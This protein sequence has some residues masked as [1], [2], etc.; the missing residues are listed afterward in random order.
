MKF[1]KLYSSNQRFPEPSSYPTESHLHWWNISS[2]LPHP[3]AELPNYTTIQ[4]PNHHC[5]TFTTKP[6]NS[7][8]TGI[9]ISLAVAATNRFTAAPWGFSSVESV[10]RLTG[11]LHYIIDNNNGIHIHTIHCNHMHNILI[12]KYMCI[13]TCDYMCVCVWWNVCIMCKDII[14]INTMLDGGA[15]LSCIPQ[16]LS[17][18]KSNHAEVIYSAI[19]T[20][21]CCKLAVPAEQSGCQLL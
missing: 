9:F 1:K 5:P 10:N 15:R 14:A 20:S 16:L 17:L 18:K 4:P 6:S 12:C 11:C 19:W 8:G 21:S 13:Y 2:V 3:T 7:S